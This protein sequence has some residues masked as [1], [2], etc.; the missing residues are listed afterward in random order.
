M[1]SAIELAYMLQ[2][3]GISQAS[4]A[5]FLGRSD[6]T[7]RRYLAGEA[8]IPPAEVLLLRALAQLRQRPLVPPRNPKPLT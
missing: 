3:Y 1:L 7:V 4:C 6:R 2:S 8:N 5:R